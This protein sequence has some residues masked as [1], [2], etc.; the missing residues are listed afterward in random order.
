MD[1][2]LVL[3]TQYIVVAACVGTYAAVTGTTVA[4]PVAIVATV[5]SIW[6]VV[7]GSASLSEFAHANGM[8]PR[9]YSTIYYVGLVMSSLGV[10]GFVQAAE[11]MIYASLSGVLLLLGVTLTLGG[12]FED[13]KRGVLS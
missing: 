6:H 4:F 1:R 5:P 7:R 3:G 12:A 8:E 11:G 2:D 10:L 9:D 13:L